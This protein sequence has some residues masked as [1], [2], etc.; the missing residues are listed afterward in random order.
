[1]NWDEVMESVKKVA[2]ATAKKV[3][4][5]ADI[6][7]LQVKRTLCERKLE[8]AHAKLGRI[9]F[10]HFTEETDLSEEIAGAVKEVDLLMREVKD[11][12][13]QIADAKR[14][15]QEASAKEAAPQDEQKPETEAK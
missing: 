3:S 14:R 7:S 13:A 1:M 2:D 12:D 5:T 8:A 15:A 11:W 9:A 6:A 10:R 4:Q